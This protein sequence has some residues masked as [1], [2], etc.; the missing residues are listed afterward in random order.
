MSERV[1]T[2]VFD[3]E[4]PAVNL[5]QQDRQPCRWGEWDELRLGYPCL[6]H[7][8]GELK[9]GSLSCSKAPGF[10]AQLERYNDHLFEREAQKL[11]EGL[12]PFPGWELI[13]ADRSGRWQVRGEVHGK[14]TKLS[15]ETV[16]DLLAKVRQACGAGPVQ[17]SLL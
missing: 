3:E 17:E 16:A 8:G 4:Q 7:K 15:G 12:K 10:F 9:V 2:G 13:G 11:R 6:T 1:V 14:S 5:E